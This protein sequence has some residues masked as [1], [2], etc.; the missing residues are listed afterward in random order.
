MRYRGRLITLWFSTM[1]LLDLAIILH[2]PLI[3]YNKEGSQ[4]DAQA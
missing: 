3:G 1:L 4:F 2:R